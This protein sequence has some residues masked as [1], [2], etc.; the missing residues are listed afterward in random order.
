M[1]ISTTIKEEKT[2]EKEIQ[3]P[4]FCKYGGYFL[5]ISSPENVI[6]ISYSENTITTIIVCDA[7]VFKTE[8]AKGEEIIEE[9][10]NKAYSKALGAIDK[11]YWYPEK[12]LVEASKE[13]EHHPDCP[14]NDGFGCHCYELPINTE[15][16][17][18]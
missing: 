16:I 4:Y 14:A 11:A 2:I 6:K 10:F 9:E 18:Q 13:E 3:L 8:I 12:T 1:K 15:A 17:N 7:G 5:K